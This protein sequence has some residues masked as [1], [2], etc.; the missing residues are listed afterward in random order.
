MDGCMC[1]RVV[2][3]MVLRFISC[4]YINQQD[5]SI[6]G[7]KSSSQPPSL[8]RLS[9]YGNH[10]TP[11]GEKKASHT[12]FAMSNKIYTLTTLD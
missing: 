4:V 10:W 8:R 3:K 9:G 11:N 5:D 2:I 7:L 12:S 1:G 6:F